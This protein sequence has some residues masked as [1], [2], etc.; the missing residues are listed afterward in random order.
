MFLCLLGKPSRT[1]YAVFLFEPFPK[2][3]REKIIELES[4]SDTFMQKRKNLN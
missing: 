2:G 1:N 4:E 3:E